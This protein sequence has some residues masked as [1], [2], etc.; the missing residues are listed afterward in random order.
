MALAEAKQMLKVTR[1]YAKIIGLSVEDSKK[2][3]PQMRRLHLNRLFLPQ[4]ALA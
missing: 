1:N 3:R 4:N 2:L